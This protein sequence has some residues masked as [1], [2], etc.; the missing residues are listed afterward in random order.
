MSIDL[1]L[2][3]G[4]FLRL[5]ISEYRRTLNGTELSPKMLDEALE[6]AHD[7]WHAYRKPKRQPRSPFTPPTPEEVTAY[8]IEIGHPLDGV[9]WCLGYEMKGWCTSGT[10]KMRNWRLA[11][12][13]WK[14]DGITTK[15]RPT[16]STKPVIHFPTLEPEGWREIITPEDE[17]YTFR[18]TEWLAILPF[19]Q[20]RI[21]KKFAVHEH[22]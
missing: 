20:Q 16:A 3:I 9:S 18:N 11:V 1:N 13:K 8:S 10:T 12:Q 2:P 17:D 6:K 22:A 4:T 14:R 15:H 5:S 21:A 7:A 19:Y